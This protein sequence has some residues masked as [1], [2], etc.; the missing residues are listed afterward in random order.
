MS[1]SVQHQRLA[2]QVGLRFQVLPSY[3]GIPH[4]T[5]AGRG[6][7]Y[8]P[9]MEVTH[10]C[11]SF[12]PAPIKWQPFIYMEEGERRTWGLWP[13]SH[14]TVS[15]RMTCKHVAPRVTLAPTCFPPGVLSSMKVWL[16]AFSKLGIMCYHPSP[17]TVTTGQTLA[18]ECSFKARP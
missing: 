6:F 18:T 17:Q 2:T 8:K 15:Q 4:P 11:N 1:S 16:S 5:S 13:G 3:G 10:K 14:L 9:S 12:L 7:C